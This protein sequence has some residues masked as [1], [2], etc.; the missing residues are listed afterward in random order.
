MILFDNVSVDMSLY[1]RIDVQTQT[2]RKLRLG[3]DVFDFGAKI[4]IIWR[5]S[6]QKKLKNKEFGQNIRTL[7]FV[8]R[9]QGAYFFTTRRSLMRA[10]LP[11]RARR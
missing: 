7:Y 10:F 9:L 6:M 3:Y 2:I 4:A 11:V 8:V 5:H 1:E